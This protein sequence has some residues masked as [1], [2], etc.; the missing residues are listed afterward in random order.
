MIAAR[1]D[2]V[3]APTLSGFASAA[4]EVL[5][6]LH[7]RVGFAACAVGRVQGDSWVVRLVEG[8]DRRLH[9]GASFRWSETICARMTTTGGPLVVPRLDE[10][11][12]YASALFARRLGVGAYAGVPLYQP[13]GSLFGTLCAISPHPMEEGVAAEAPL[14]GLSARL[15]AAALANDERVAAQWQ[16]SER[17][18]LWSHVDRAT[19][20]HGRLAWKSILAFEEARCRR[21]GHPASVVVVDFDLPE[22][23]PGA[24]GSAGPATDLVRSVTE[25]V[26]GQV[27]SSDLLARTDTRQLSVLATDA[28][29]G[30]EILAGRLRRAL[31]GQGVQATTAVAD[32]AAYGGLEEAWQ[33]LCGGGGPAAARPL[34]SGA[35]RTYETCGACHRKG[36]YVSA[37]FPVLR[38]K[39]CRTCRELTM[40]EWTEAS[41]GF[42]H[43]A[44]E[45]GADRLL[46]A[47]A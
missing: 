4:R 37:T 32:R 47:R 18:A 42:A 43:L 2:T 6:D 3:A 24:T 25:A 11:Q 41:R 19:G 1:P 39:L 10:V 20:L 36:A 31:A 8:D 15:L 30:A 35:V 40:V 34:P 23:V 12:R 14:L 33:A 26:A 5:A 27:R 16:V 7:D 21:H 29:G 17:R 28:S 46:A 45:L 13:D 22:G 38:C 44:A 9:A